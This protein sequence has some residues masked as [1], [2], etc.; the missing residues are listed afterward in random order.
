[1][2]LSEVSQVL[3]AVQGA[4]YGMCRTL[5]LFSFENVPGFSLVPRNENKVQPDLRQTKK[6]TNAENCS[7]SHQGHQIE[8]DVLIFSDNAR[9]VIAGRDFSSMAFDTQLRTARNGQLKP[10]QT[11]TAPSSKPRDR[12]THA[13]IRLLSHDVSTE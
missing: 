9:K 6:T 13:N 12:Y 5:T 7:I 11:A 4:F 8:R 10:D 3:V 2:S 1:M